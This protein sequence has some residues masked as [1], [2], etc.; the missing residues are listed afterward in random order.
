MSITPLTKPLINL[1]K[2]DGN[3]NVNIKKGKN[4]K[5]IINTIKV[6]NNG[7]CIIILVGANALT[8]LYDG[9]HIEY[10]AAS[11]PDKY[12]AAIICHKSIPSSPYIINTFASVQ[13][14][15]YHKLVKDRTCLQILNE[16]SKYL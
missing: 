6:D 5:N 14:C 13:V 4:I 2:F 8:N 10:I 3:I 9:H 11:T 7:F 16:E 15:P 12:T 1:S